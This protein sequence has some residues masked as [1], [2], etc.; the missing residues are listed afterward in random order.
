MGVAAFVKLPDPLL[1]KND[2]IE[3]WRLIQIQVAVAIACKNQPVS[4]ADYTHIAKTYKPQSR[5]QQPWHMAER[6]LPV[7]KGGDTLPN[8]LGVVPDDCYVFY[9]DN[10]GVMGAPN[11]Y[12]RRKTRSRRPDPNFTLDG[13]CQTCENPKATDQ[14]HRDYR[15]SLTNENSIRQCRSCNRPDK[16]NVI[17]GEGSRPR[18]IGYSAKGLQRVVKNSDISVEKSDRILEILK[19]IA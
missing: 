5:Q 6:G 19:D 9:V 13:G 1:K 4:I 2:R 15:K 16:N 7:Y 18:A 10:N 14:G 11:S 17:W 3:N 12:D 8:A